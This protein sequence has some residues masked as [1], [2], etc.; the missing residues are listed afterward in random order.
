MGLL[1]YETPENHFIFN[2]YIPQRIPSPIGLPQYSF[3]SQ[4]NLNYPNLIFQ[5]KIPALNPLVQNSKLH[6][7]SMGF[8]GDETITIQR[9]NYN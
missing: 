8:S 2:P 9:G 1:P 6:N 3:Q 4:M 5:T 7:L